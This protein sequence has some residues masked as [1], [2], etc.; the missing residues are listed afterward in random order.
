MSYCGSFL[1]N[2]DEQMDITESRLKRLTRRIEAA[3]SSALG[4]EEFRILRGS[5]F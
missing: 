5:N 4:T 3:Y 1:Q 2:M